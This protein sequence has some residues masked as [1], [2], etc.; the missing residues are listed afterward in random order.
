M[1]GVHQVVVDGGRMGVAAG[2]GGGGTGLRSLFDRL[3][4]VDQGTRG[5]TLG[6]TRLSE[7][8]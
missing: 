3:I 1:W 8:R 5:N 6:D 4:G 7:F 2:V